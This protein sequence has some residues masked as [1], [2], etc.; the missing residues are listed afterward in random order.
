MCVC[1]CVCVV[2]LKYFFP[3]MAEYWPELHTYK[4]VLSTSKLCAPI[5]CFTRWRGLMNT[6][7]D[8]VFC[9]KRR[10]IFVLFCGNL[11]FCSIAISL[12]PDFELSPSL[13][14]RAWV[15]GILD[16]WIQEGEYLF[17]LWQPSF[18]FIVQVSNWRSG[19]VEELCLRYWGCLWSKRVAQPVSSLDWPRQGDCER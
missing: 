11:L 16:C 18:F 4:L 2:E 9:G 10:W 7:W 12:T 17:C 19:R 6:T 1:V 13:S 14:C 8:L 15:M 5:S 3:F